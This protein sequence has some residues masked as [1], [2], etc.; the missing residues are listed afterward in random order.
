MDNKQIELNED[1]NDMMPL[2]LDISCEE[3]EIDLEVDIDQAKIQQSNSQSKSC[4][5]TTNIDTF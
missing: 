2:Y 3:L 1:E 4:L 5:I